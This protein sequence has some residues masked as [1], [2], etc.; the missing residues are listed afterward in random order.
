MF[1][2][3]DIWHSF[4]SAEMLFNLT[5]LLRVTELSFALHFLFVNFQPEF[6]I[7]AQPVG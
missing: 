4:F 5:E 1:A 6:P 3:I 7:H 2:R